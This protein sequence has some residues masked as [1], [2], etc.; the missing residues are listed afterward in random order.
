MYLRLGAIAVGCPT[1]TGLRKHW[2]GPAQ[3]LR[4]GRSDITVDPA[5]FVAI[6]YALAERGALQPRGPASSGSA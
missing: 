1:S 2:T 5:A 3:G 4:R 6:Q